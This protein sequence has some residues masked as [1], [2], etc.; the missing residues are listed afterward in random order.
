MP[1]AAKKIRVKGFL[2]HADFPQIGADGRPE[3]HHTLIWP[4]LFPRHRKS[5]LPTSEKEQAAFL[6]AMLQA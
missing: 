3:I 6:L 2:S 1:R 4:D 5:R